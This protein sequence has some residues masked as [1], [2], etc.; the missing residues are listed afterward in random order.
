MA[1]KAPAYALSFEAG[2]VVSTETANTMVDGVA[3]RTPDPLG[4]WTSGRHD[5]L[6]AAGDQRHP[7]VFELA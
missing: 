1:E 6:A 3:C 2:E 5:R 4:D 7:A